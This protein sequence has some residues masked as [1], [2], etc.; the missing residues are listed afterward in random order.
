MDSS[1]DGAPVARF[2]AAGIAVVL[3]VAAVVMVTVAL[4]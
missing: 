2:A 4:G 1:G 3:I